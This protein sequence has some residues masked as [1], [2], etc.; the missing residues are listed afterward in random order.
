MIKINIVNLFK[1]KFSMKICIILLSFIFINR[2]ADAAGELADISPLVRYDG[3]SEW[4]KIP[5][6]KAE[7]DRLSETADKLQDVIT[8]VAIANTEQWGPDFIFGNPKRNE[9][10]TLCM[11]FCLVLS[12]RAEDLNSSKA[13]H[14]FEDKVLEGAQLLF[15]SGCG[16]PLIHDVDMIVW[17]FKMF[18]SPSNHSLSMQDEQFDFSRAR[19]EEWEGK[20]GI[21]QAR[22]LTDELERTVE[23]IKKM[24]GIKSH[25]GYDLEMVLS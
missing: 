20:N 3:T 25:F 23:N 18:V 5:V 17:K 13:V 7:I 24:L 2:V 14:C 21:Q 9:N 22:F 10:Y 19:K 11:N 12:E 1:T 15:R 4:V 6:V 8:A 16:H